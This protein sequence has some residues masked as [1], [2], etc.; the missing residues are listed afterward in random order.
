MTLIR[1]GYAFRI[2]VSER[3]KIVCDKLFQHRLSPGQATATQSTW[4]G[5]LLG[6]VAGLRRPA[7]RQADASAAS[8]APRRCPPAPTKAMLQASASTFPSYVPTRTANKHSL[9]FLRWEKANSVTE[10]TSNSPRLQTRSTM[11]L[12]HRKLRY[13]QVLPGSPPR[14]CAA[15]TDF[16][17]YVTLYALYSQF[18]HQT[19]KHLVFSPCSLS[20]QVRE[21]ESYKGKGQNCT[22]L[23]KP[24]K[25]TE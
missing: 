12:R 2:R 7:S 11:S 9:F 14:P 18:T 17:V 13:H 8:H 23:L 20:Q 4:P 22:C 15:S 25:G 21:K 10:Q 1:I 3:E 5:L 19:P 16:P 6:T 24:S